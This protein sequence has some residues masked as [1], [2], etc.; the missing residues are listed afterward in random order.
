M[1]QVTCEV[2]NGQ[3]GKLVTDSRLKALLQFVAWRIKGRKV[4]MARYES[5]AQPLRQAADLVDRRNDDHRED[6]T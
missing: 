5:D 1:W 2:G 3:T 6:E 4:A